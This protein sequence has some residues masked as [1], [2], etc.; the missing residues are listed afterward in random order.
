[1]TQ[2]YLSPESMKIIKSSTQ[3][4]GAS[5]QMILTNENDFWSVGIIFLE[6]AFVEPLHTSIYNWDD[7]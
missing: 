5:R 2:A 1:M 4:L 3:K 7:L 6:L